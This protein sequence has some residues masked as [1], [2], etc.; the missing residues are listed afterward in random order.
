MKLL[1]L[2]EELGPFLTD[3][4]VTSRAQGTLILSTMLK[5]LPK[6]FLNEI[7]LNFVTTFYCDRMKD[8]FE[9]IPAV[10]QGILAIVRKNNISKKNFTVDLGN[11]KK[12]N[13]IDYVKLK[14]LDDYNYSFNIAGRN[15]AI[16]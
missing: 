5:Q 14:I 2:V 6:D 15:E 8:N 4:N 12:K 3:K 7:E 1:S 16:T 11:L 9:V 13:Q 10:L